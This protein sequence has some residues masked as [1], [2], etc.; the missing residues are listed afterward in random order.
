[1]AIDSLSVSIFSL[2]FREFSLFIPSSRAAHPLTPSS[3]AAQ[4]RGDPVPLPLSLS[5]LLHTF[6]VR[7]DGSGGITGLLPALLRSQSQ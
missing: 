4:Q 6:G 3:R 1:M 2:C 5:G 7:N